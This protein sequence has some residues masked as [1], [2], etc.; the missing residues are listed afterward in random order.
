MSY[1]KSLTALLTFMGALAE[2]YQEIG[3]DGVK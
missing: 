1:V 2:P 3:K